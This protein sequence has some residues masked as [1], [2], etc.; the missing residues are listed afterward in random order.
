MEN[1][2]PR[3]SVIMP[4]YNAEKYLREA[5]DSILNQTFSD[6]EFLIF[7]DGSTDNSSEIIKSIKDDRIKFFD[8]KNNSGYVKH[9][10]NGLDIAKGEFIARMDADD[11]S[12]PFRF[13]K[14]IDVLI[15]NLD[16]GLC[17][18]WYKE[19]DGIQEFKFSE[20]HFTLMD[21]MLEYNPICHPGV[22][23][24]KS[25]LEENN[26]NYENDYVPAEDYFLWTKLSKYCNFYCIQEFLLHYRIHPASISF[27]K[28]VRQIQNIEISKMSIIL[29]N[30]NVSSEEKNFLINITTNKEIIVD[31]HILLK[32]DYLFNKI[33]KGNRVFNSNLLKNKLTKIW[34]NTFHKT[35]KYYPNGI[36]LY[37][38]P[39]F[40]ELSF[41]TKKF[42][43]LSCLFKRISNLTLIESFLFSLKKRK[44]N[45]ELNFSFKMLKLYRSNSFISKDTPKIGE[46]SYFIVYNDNSKINIR[47]NVELRRNILISIFGGYL[48]IG[49]NVF[50]NNNT[51][52]N[53]FERIIIGE[54]T[55]IGEG[56]KIYDHNHKI[57][58]MPNGIQNVS[59]DE[60]NT[61]S[62]IIGSNCWIGSNVT[63]L[64][65]VEIGDNVVIGACNLIYKSVPA[66]TIVMSKSEKIVK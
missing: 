31:T 20:N 8:Y 38:S 4:V 23:L 63:I 21:E 15:N 66:N 58:E 43:Y 19:I 25:I 16:V 3:L 46:G 55:L 61:E 56:V 37:R 9:L 64:K 45:P 2:S 12:M 47:K 1:H 62:V 50:I 6:F 44:F 52:I 5:I 48:E 35:I 59:R 27:R 13:Q 49:E 60:F 36:L 24:R 41:S 28:R 34:L 42:Y 51:S 7:N 39:F 53:C 29:V 18:C 17:T 22:M 10:N 65:G 54:N 26:L 32:L 33:I 11:I 30:S 40:K 57:Q 14:Q